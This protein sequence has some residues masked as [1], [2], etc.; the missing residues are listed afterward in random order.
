M[1]SDRLTHKKREQTKKEKK[2]KK[3]PYLEIN[4]L[5]MKK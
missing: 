3:N 4:Y 2:S 1:P 5:F